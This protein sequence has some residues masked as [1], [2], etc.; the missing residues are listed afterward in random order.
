[1]IFDGSDLLFYFFFSLFAFDFL[2]FLAFDVPNVVIFFCLFIFT[3]SSTNTHPTTTPNMILKTLLGS[4]KV[5]KAQNR[6]KTY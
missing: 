1:M 5:Q 2:F 6:R 4:S 3:F